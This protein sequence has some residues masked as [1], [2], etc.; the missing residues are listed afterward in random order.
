MTTRRAYCERWK[1]DI[2]PRIFGILEK[3]KKESAWCIPKLAGE[4]LYAVK[5]Q[6]GSQVVVDLARHSCSCRRW[7]ITG[8]PC[9]HAC[10]VIGQLNGDHIAYVDACY[11]KEAFMRAYSPMVRRRLETGQ[12]SE[13]AQCS[14]TAHAFETAQA[15][16]PAPASKT[17]P[18]SQTT[19]ASQTAKK[20]RFKSL[21]MRIKFTKMKDG[22]Q[23]VHG[24]Q[25]SASSSHAVLQTKRGSNLLLRGRN[26]PIERICWMVISLG[27]SDDV[28]V[29][30]VLLKC[31]L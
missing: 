28:Q 21:A 19:Q 14:Q 1:H 3:T 15:S 13:I 5:N 24:S 16:Q 31:L 23:T 20:E 12:C 7:D 10:A 30:Y 25:P 22:S 8:I 17:A 6:D 26:L 18:T 4:S 27:N 29:F 11:K 9:K 2:G